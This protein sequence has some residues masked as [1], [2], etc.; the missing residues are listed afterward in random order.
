ML[1][2]LVQSHELIEIINK[3]DLIKS[4]CGV[5]K[6]W[7]DIVKITPDSIHAKEGEGFKARF[8]SRSVLKNGI[9]PRLLIALDSEGVFNHL[10]KRFGLKIIEQFYLEDNPLL[11][12]KLKY[13]S[14][15][16]SPDANPETNSVDG[17]V[18]RS[19]VSELYSTIRG[20][21]GTTVDDSGSLIDMRIIATATTDRYSDLTRGICIFNTAS[22]GAS[23][24]V[25]E[26]DL[27]LTPGING[28]DVNS[29][30]PSF[31][32]FSVTTSSSTSLATGDYAV[33]NFGST[34]FSENSPLQS[35]LSLDT[36]Y[37]WPLNSSGKNHISKTSVTKFGLRDDFDYNNS[38]PGWISG[39]DSRMFFYDA[40]N[41]T[42]IPRLD[43]TYFPLNLRSP[44]TLLGVG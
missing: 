42:N 4:Y 5:P 27:N 29:F 11:T 26:A 44:L 14:A 39:G 10:E 9:N 32:W 31:S 40:E 8:Y 22:L 28:N 1:K 33:A 36:E 23:V 13:A 30:D 24:Y 2:N 37:S 20:G 17:Y 18:R 25:S 16:F 43:V 38:D 3:S 12:S 34:Q 19:G 41:I 7:K 6:N 21:A 15:S 35:T